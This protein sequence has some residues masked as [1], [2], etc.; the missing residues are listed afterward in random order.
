MSQS[1]VSKPGSLG[2]PL[3]LNDLIPI[4]DCEIPNI[5][6]NAKSALSS[7]ERKGLGPCKSNGGMDSPHGS[8]FEKA[9]FL[10]RVLMIKHMLA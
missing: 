7:G 9:R 2:G 5:Q 4:K 10:L 6:K 1:L 3:L 8:P